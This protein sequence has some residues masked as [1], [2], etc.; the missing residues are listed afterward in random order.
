MP[1]LKPSLLPLL[2]Q[3]NAEQRRLLLRGFSAGQLKALGYL[4]PL[5][6][7][8]KQLPPKG[9]WQV[10]LLMAGRGFGKTRA[11]AEWIRTQAESGKRPALGLV[12]ATFDDVRHVMVEGPS[13]ILSIAP[14]DTRPQWFVSRRLL[15]W[16]NGARATV[17]SADRPDQLRGPEFEYVWADEIAKWRYEEAWINLRLCMRKGHAPKIL[18]TTTPRPKI[19]LKQLAEDSYTQLVSGSSAE[20]AANLAPGFAEI[21]RAQLHS[22]DLVRQELEGALLTA[23][24]GALWTRDQLN[25]LVYDM[26]CRGDMPSIVVGVDPAIGGKD[27]T[28]I[29]VAGKDKDGLY[30][31]LEDAS[32]HAPADIW[33]QKV[34][35]MA[36][37]WRAEAIIAEVNQGGDLVRHLL[38]NSR[39]GRSAIP[40]VRP[41]RALRGKTDRALPIAAAYARDEVRHAECFHSLC[42]QMAMSVPGI[43]QSPSPDR[44][45][46]LVWA[47]SY[48]LRGAE[49]SS[50]ELRL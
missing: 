38:H 3:T 16:P 32:L 1:N 50:E 14:E 26:P 49:T 37:K 46:A 19:W 28:G 30:W 8:D 9:D 25:A 24:A 13:G 35:R 4:W 31:V 34:C 36:E 27:E 42:D 18:A 11:G 29:I 17:F 47:L 5:W 10:W 33:A 41:A 39:L 6:A 12:G 40:P 23:Y 21:L 43:T 7:R 22:D 15:I 20:N 48:L 45:D 2:V 44:L